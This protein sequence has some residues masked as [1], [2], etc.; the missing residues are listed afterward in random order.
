[1]VSEMMAGKP[2]IWAPSLGCVRRG[3]ERSREDILDFQDIAVGD[4]D[5][6]FGNVGG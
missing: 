6:G 3:F 4:G 2:S 5:S 1:M